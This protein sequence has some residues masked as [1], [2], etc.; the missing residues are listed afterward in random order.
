MSRGLP[1]FPEA[2]STIASGVDLVYFFMVAVSVFFSVGIFTA[3]FYFALR[4][5]RQ[6]PDEVP[7]PIEGSLQLEILWSVGPFLITMVMFGWGTALFF[8]NVNP[9]PGAMEMY[10]VG[11]Q[12]MWKIQHPEGH[13]EINE[14]HVP[15]G[16]PVKLT[17]STEDV[18]HSF[19]IPAFRVKKDVVPGMYTS[20]WF[21]ATK[22][23]QYHLFCAEYCGTQHSGMRGTVHVMEPADYEA[24]L[25]GSPRGE[26]M[27]QAGERVFQR[28]GCFTCH[29]ADTPGRG[30]SLEGVF[31]SD[32]RLQNGQTVRAD[33]AYLRESI[34]RP[35]AKIVAGFSTQMPTFQGQIS[36]E[37][38]MQII[39]YIKSLA[40]RQGPETARPKQ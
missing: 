32:V 5:R 6:H 25:S 2:A 19:F 33:E 8:R 16:V 15:V 28:L 39:A 29:R 21:E 18:I 11:K 38:L 12:W 23:G 17:M 26:T 14:L 20:L 40:E 35:Q 27:V 3:I 9:P 10:V 34:L 36:E 7:K 4:Y 30:P 31:G 1:L 22:A 13:R 24:W 37:G